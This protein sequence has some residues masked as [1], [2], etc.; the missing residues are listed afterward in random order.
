MQKVN[1]LNLLLAIFFPPLGALLQVGLSAHFFLNIL[2]TLCGVLPGVI[3][4]VWLVL[5]NK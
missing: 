3:H 5:K 1:P 4:A 2:L